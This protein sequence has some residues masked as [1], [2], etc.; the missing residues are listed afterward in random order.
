MN[1]MMSWALNPNLTG[2]MVMLTEKKS[3]FIR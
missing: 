3:S 1:L 2:N